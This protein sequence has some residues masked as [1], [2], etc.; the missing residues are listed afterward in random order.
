MGLRDLSSTGAQND[1]E[2]ARGVRNAPVNPHL[3]VAPNVPSG[4]T[5]T[6]PDPNTPR[7]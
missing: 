4:Q 3:R 6:L 1:L 7:I 2:T 5:L